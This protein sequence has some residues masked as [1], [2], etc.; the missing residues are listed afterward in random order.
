MKGFETR[1][2]INNTLIGTCVTSAVLLR[3][4]M[5]VWS[6]RPFLPSSGDTDTSC[7]RLCVTLKP[8]LRVSRTL[9]QHFSW[10]NSCKF[11]PSCMFS[12]FEKKNNSF[13]CINFTNSNARPLCSECINGDIQRSSVLSQNCHAF[14][15]ATVV[16]LEGK[17][18]TPPSLVSICVLNK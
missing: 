6:F 15:L 14:H 2:S 10:S 4:T 16:S 18:I 3:V 5:D 1:R 8:R 9:G 12:C 13:S 17:E 11:L 7:A